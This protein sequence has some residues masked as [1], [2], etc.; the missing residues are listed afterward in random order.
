[1]KT[2][3][4][5]AFFLLLSMTLLSQKTKNKPATFGSIEPVG[6]I[7][8]LS[9][10]ALLDVVQRQT[11]RYFW[12]FAHPVSGMARERSNNTFGYGDEVVTSGGTGFGVMATIVAVERGWITRDTA[13][14]F[15]LKMVKFLAKAE[16]YHGVFPHWLD[17]ETGKTIPFSRKDD[18]AD[19][20]ETSYLFQGLLCVR[21]YFNENNN[22]ERELRNRINWL[23][24]DIEWDWFTR[25]GQEVLYWHWSPNNDWAMNFPVR[26]FNECLIMYIL[27]ASG[28]NHPVSADV[29]HRGWVQSDFFKNGKEFYGYKLP[30]GF[31][32]G[33]PLFF[34][35][36]SFLGLDPR[37]LSDRYANYWE[38]NQNH[39][40][41]NR[42]YCLDNPNK[43]KGYGENC[44]GLTASD[45]HEGYNA[46]SPTNDLGVIT[47]TAAL[48]AFPYTPEYSMQALRHFYYDLGDKIWGEYGFVDA[49]N[50]T[51][52][53]YAKSYLAIDEGPIVVMI[54]NYR[55]GLLWKLF[56]SCPEIQQGLKKLDF[57]S[58]YY[59]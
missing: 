5:F 15:L 19:L 36:Y 31:D 42:A 12:D 18:G 16:A 51:K 3:I 46:H 44:W 50:E 25:G 23:W 55:S 1:M 59:K 49:F 38:Q 39:T 52:N 33:G 58:P 4:T 22:I 48:S 30:L 26:G 37:G 56:M 28:E 20:V 7:K 13:A 47:P 43:F 41:I 14:K 24:N 8:G 54:E 34:S 21:Q 29:Y 40:L 35:H 32:Y 6:I 57:Q 10:S 2:K 53:W 45:N 17:G 27:A 9:D 11:F